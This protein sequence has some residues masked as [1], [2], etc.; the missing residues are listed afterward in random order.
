MTEKICSKCLKPLP[1]QEPG[2]VTFHICNTAWKSDVLKGEVVNDLLEL[3][4]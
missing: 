4:Q 2:Y 3:D 1:V